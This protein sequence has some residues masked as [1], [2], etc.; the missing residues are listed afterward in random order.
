MTEIPHKEM[1]V[2][3]FSLSAVG[4]FLAVACGAPVKQPP[5]AA[6]PAT[7]LAC[8][9]PQ[10]GS[11]Y[12]LCGEVTTTTPL[13]ASAKHALAGALDDVSANATGEHHRIEKAAV[14]AVP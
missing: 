4:L 12:Q 14:H 3:W 6:V 9:T 10:R 7:R 2:P 5:D 8:D 1:T 13:Q 11:R